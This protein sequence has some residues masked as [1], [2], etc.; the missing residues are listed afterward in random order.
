[1]R[2]YCPRMSVKESWPLNPAAQKKPDLQAAIGLAG[3]GSGDDR[4]RRG[5]DR[6]RAGP[7][8]AHGAA[9]HTPVRPPSCHKQGSIMSGAGPGRHKQTKFGIGRSSSVQL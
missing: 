8:A 4:L 5:R 1:M 7:D 9:Q 3:Q 2:Q 6:L